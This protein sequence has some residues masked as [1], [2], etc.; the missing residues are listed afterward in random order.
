MN[1]PIQAR[2]LLVLGYGNPGRLDDGL[3]PAFADAIEQENLPGITVQSAWQLEVEHAAVVAT[4]RHVIFVDAVE[5]V[6]K[7]YVFQRICPKYSLTFST[8]SIQPDIIMGL[9]IKL[10]GA[11][12][13][14]FLLGIRGYSFNHFQKKLSDGANSNLALAIKYFR[15]SVWP[16]LARKNNKSLPMNWGKNESGFLADRGTVSGY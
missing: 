5:S 6:D 7:A 2:T 12:T 1:E 14:G 16:A 15:Y 10:F 4:H 8:H 13:T 3:G 9:A 11:R